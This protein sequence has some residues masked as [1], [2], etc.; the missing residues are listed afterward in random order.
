[1]KLIQNP[2]NMKLKNLAVTNSYMN[3]SNYIVVDYI[4]I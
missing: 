4:E 1:M 3:Y 2:L